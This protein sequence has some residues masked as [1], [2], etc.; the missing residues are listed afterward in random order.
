V[1]KQEQITSDSVKN[2][3]ELLP[4]DEKCNQNLVNTIGLP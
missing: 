1:K 2:K 4:V 3:D